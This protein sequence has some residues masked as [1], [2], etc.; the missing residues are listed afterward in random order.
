MNIGTQRFLGTTPQRTLQL[1]DADRT[2]LPCG[3]ST[4]IGH[5][6]GRNFCAAGAV[7][8]VILGRYP[9][10]LEA[11][12]AAL[13]EVHSATEAVARSCDMA[14]NTQEHISGRLRLDPERRAEP[15]LQF[16]FEQRQQRP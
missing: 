2:F 9:D 7:K 6:I 3:D 13:E 12:A 11:S 15:P 10:I 14:D 5:A 16:S 8:A 1:S 4:D